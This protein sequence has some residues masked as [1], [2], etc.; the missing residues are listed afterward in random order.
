MMETRDKYAV[1]FI[2]PEVAIGP[3]RTYSG[4]LGFFSGGFLMSAKK[5]GLPV[6]GMTTFP[7]QGYYDQGID[8]NGMTINFV[9]RYYKDILEK[10]GVK[11]TINVCSH[12]VWIEILRFPSEK[13]NC[14]E[15]Y[16]L[17][18]DI[19]DNDYLSRLITL[20]LYGGSKR[21]G[22]NIERR[23]AQEIIL[24]KGSLLAYRHLGIP[25]R[26]YH[27]NESHGVLAAVEYLELLTRNG[28][29][30]DSALKKTRSKF[31]F[32]THTPVSAGN[33]EYDL[34][35]LSKMLGEY[36]KDNL[37]KIG[38]NPFSMT[39]AAFYLAGRANAVSKKHLKTAKKM[40][41]R[42]E[43]EK[44][45]ICITNGTNL[46]Y[47]RYP[48]FTE[49]KTPARLKKVKEIYKQKMI[50]FIFEKTGRRFEKSVFTVVWARRFEEYKRPKLIF[51][52]FEWLKSNLAGE[53]FQLIFAGKPH[54]DN[55]QM[56]NVWN[57][58]FRLSV[59]WP[60]LVILPDYDYEMSKI[61][62]AGT[63]IWLNAPR[64]PFEASGTS[65]MC[66]EAIHM[67][68]RD[69]WAL[70]QNPKNCFLF[71]SDKEIPNQDEH[72]AKELIQCIER[73]KKMF[74]YQPGLWYRKA[75]RAKFESEERWTTDRMVKQYSE[76]LYGI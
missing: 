8:A 54:P 12:P 26:L 65:G 69:G 35:L 32:T 29:S 41:E 10:T 28:A 63:D 55:Q 23:I 59:V 70:E 22:A 62:K 24:G 60:N 39:A 34:N 50:D 45:P 20:Q 64:A 52:D 37:F 5:L 56:I 15:L 17:S 75:L 19:N 46:A 7:T 76:L 1:A 73:A 13:Y 18:T 61:L 30:F 38:G 21:T 40:W 66:G 57:E 11:F 27:L 67:S 49:A 48:E 53:K 2:T 33:P 44:P 72:D 71:G 9:N 31:V 43:K 42:V 68:T 25:V 6:V 4:G 14:A 74:Y 51:H 58:I 16:F 3:L 47:W 36:Y